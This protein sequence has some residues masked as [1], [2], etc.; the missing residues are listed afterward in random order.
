MS[1][2]SRPLAYTSTHV[3]LRHA[4]VLAQL[5]LNHTLKK[6]AAGGYMIDLSRQRDGNKTSR[7]YGPFAASL[8]D[9]LTPVLDKYCAMLKFDDVGETGPY[10]FHPPQGSTLTVPWSRAHG[11]NG[12]LAA[13][14]ATQAWPLRQRRCAASSCTRTPPLSSLPCHP[15]HPR[16]AHAIAKRLSPVPPLAALGSETT[17]ATA[18]S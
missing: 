10:L 14:N 1:R 5:R 8:P 4:C 9:A 12:Y 16:P 18:P 11:A 13:S 3:S 6:K 17:P 15:P 7:F 2:L